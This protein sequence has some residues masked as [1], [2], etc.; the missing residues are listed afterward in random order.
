MMGPVC[1]AMVSVTGNI[2]YSIVNSWDSYIYAIVSAVVGMSVGICAKKGY[3]KSF[4]GA[5]SISFFV[6]VLSVLLSVPLNFRFSGGYTQNIWG[7][8]IIDAMKL[9]GFN[10]FFRLLHGTV[11][12]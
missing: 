2:I 6:T 3:L 11:L 4:F 1:G 12:S 10:N 7:D 5:L 9:I 8:G